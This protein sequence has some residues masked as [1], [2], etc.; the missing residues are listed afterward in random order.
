MPNPQETDYTAR[1]LAA[2]IRGIIEKGIADGQPM[3][4]TELAAAVL[5]LHP[6]P[7]PYGGANV[8]DFVTF[9]CYWLV[10]EQVHKIL[11]NMK[12]RRDQRQ[13]MLPGFERVLPAYIVMRPNPA[14]GSAGEPVETIVPVAQMTVAELEA[15]AAEYDTM[16]DG[17]RQHA[18]QLRKLALSRQIDGLTANATRAIRLDDHAISGGA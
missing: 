12:T 18:D 6:L 5:A 1:Q 16:A 7:P 15:K 3:P 13:H 4:A 11:A 9:A 2:E 14:P 8:R 10:R 17:C